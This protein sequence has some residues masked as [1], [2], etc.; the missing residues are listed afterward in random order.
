VVV[1]SIAPPDTLGGGV[2][3]DAH[4]ARHG[5]GPAVRARLDAVRAGAAQPSGRPD[6]RSAGG[7]AADPPAVRAAPSPEPLSEA[8]LALEARLLAAGHEPP[9]EAELGDDAEA[10]AALRAAGRAVRLGRSM[11][12]HP[13][14][15]DEVRRRVEGI[16]GAEGGITM[17][18]LRDELGT[19]RKY[20]QA[21]L[22]QL[23]S[24]RVTLRL[25]DDRRVLRRRSGRE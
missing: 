2:V 15:L 6:G 25:P 10:L 14:A 3:L 20:A 5:A 7:P 24:A 23:D 19:S 22:E 12:A 8:A 11:Y 18:R 21:L 4:P 17:A 9:S 1:R 16:I 13:A